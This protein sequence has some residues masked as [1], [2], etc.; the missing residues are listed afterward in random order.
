MSKYDAV[1]RL[2]NMATEK[3]VPVQRVH[4][5]PEHPQPEA[6][7]RDAKT[8]LAQQ[9]MASEAGA[10]APA[11]HEQA[12][13]AEPAAPRMTRTDRGRQLLGALRPF[14]PVVGGALRMVDHGAVQAVAR[15]LPLLAG[16]GGA[17]GASNGGAGASGATGEARE[18]LAQILGA[19]DK[20]QMVLAEELKSSK[21]RIGLLEEQLRRTRESLE[22]TA[23]EQNA[24][25]NTLRLLGDRSKLLMAG[26]VILLIL[27][28]AQMVL[29]VI[30]MRR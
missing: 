3:A 16:A 9:M 28:V 18:Q 13:T 20:Q 11:E 22:R 5:R 1:D 12:A 26:L 23:G 7:A 8:V 27:V 15:L 24:Q 2:M 29:F 25:S 30:F 6:K 19:F 4:P 10:A 21:Q 14:L 17:A